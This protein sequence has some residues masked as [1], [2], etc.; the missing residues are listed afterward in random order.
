MIIYMDKSAAK[1]ADLIANHDKFY[2]NKNTLEN[3]SSYTADSPLED[4][5]VTIIGHTTEARNT[6]GN[7]TAP[8]IAKS[9]ANRYK[10]NKKTLTDLF[11]VACESGTKTTKSGVFWGSTKSPSFAQQLADEMYKLGFVNINVYSV[12]PPEGADAIRVTIDKDGLAPGAVRAV[13]YMNPETTNYEDNKSTKNIKRPINHAK[14]TIMNAEK[15]HQETFKAVDSKH[16]PSQ[17]KE[18]HSLTP[19]A[20]DSKHIPSQ[21]K[22]SH[23]LTPDETPHE[24]YLEK[25]LA[26][27]GI[28]W[29]L[30]YAVF[31]A[32]SITNLLAQ[33]L[34]LIKKDEREVLNELDQFK[35]ENN[36]KITEKTS[37]TACLMNTAS[38]AFSSEGTNEHWQSLA[39]YLALDPNADILT[40]ED[41]WNNLNN[42]TS[43]KSDPDFPDLKN[44][45]QSL[46]K[47]IITIKEGKQNIKDGLLTIINDYIKKNQGSTHQSKREI[48]GEIK[49]YL[50]NPTENNWNSVT[51]KAEQHTGWDKGFFSRVRDIKEQT[52][53][54]HDLMMKKNP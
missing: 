6:V 40:R 27:N 46:H 25:L 23:S 21:K 7:K 30:F 20:V 38:K 5:S 44:Q 43:T 49:K 48:M 15:T 36:A 19:K 9:L 17:K 13:A 8:Q 54:F 28:L 29:R 42:Q 24:K 3:I 33:Q 14:Q 16:I 2:S 50:N 10:E 12:K 4:K 35:T 22:E 11:L 41:A 31:G 1:E 34:R 39:K 26:K 52:E 47:K 37:T 51:I 18:S 32:P 45:V 53:I